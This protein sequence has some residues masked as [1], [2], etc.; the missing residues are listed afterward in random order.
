[1]NPHTTP[2]KRSFHDPSHAFQRMIFSLSLS[3]SLSL[4]VA[5]SPLTLAVAL[6]LSHSRCCSDTRLLPPSLPASLPPALPPS[7]PPS[8][9]RSRS[10]ALSLSLSLSLFSLR[11]RRVL[12]PK[13]SEACVTTE[14]GSTLEPGR[15]L[16]R[17]L[18]AITKDLCSGS[19]FESLCSFWRLMWQ[20]GSVLREVSIWF[21]SI[22]RDI[23]SIVSIG[24]GFQDD[25]NAS[26]SRVFASEISRLIQG[27]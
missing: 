19:G 12:S 26:A 13:L 5:F 3:L 11:F 1:M 16:L 4:F 6:P 17:S 27:R 7:L 8:L 14:S 20:P 10:L 22:S 23:P 24:F 2:V 18:D 15:C 21:L 25:G 9:S